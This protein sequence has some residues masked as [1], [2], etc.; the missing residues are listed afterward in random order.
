MITLDR[1]LLTGLSLVWLS[2]GLNVV[3]QSTTPQALRL[4]HATGDT[5][6]ITP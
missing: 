5:V 1:I 2:S 3:G 4:D 6:K